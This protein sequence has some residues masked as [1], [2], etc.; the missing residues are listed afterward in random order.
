MRERE[1]WVDAV[2]GLAIY[3]VI[4]GHAIQYATSQDYN[5]AGNSIFQ[6]I[7]SFHMPLFM[8]MSGYLFAYSMNKYSIKGG[9]IAKVRGILVPCISWGI[10]TYLIDLILYRNQKIGIVAA[11]DYTYNS[12]WFLWA[13]FFTSILAYIFIS[14]FKKK[15]VSLAILAVINFVLPDTPEYFH[16]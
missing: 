11:L 16:I 14:V 9:M 2:K 15:E 3:L 13:V 7:Y 4:L 6:I 1:K 5:Y 12:N 10:I 8:M